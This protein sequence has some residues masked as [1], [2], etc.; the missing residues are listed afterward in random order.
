MPDIEALKRRVCEAIDRRAS[1]LIETADWIHAHPEIGHQEREASKRLADRLSEGGAQVEMGTAGMETAFSAELLG[2]SA[3]PKIAVL[4]EYDALPK[5]GH[6]CGH[7]LIAMSALGAGLALSEVLG[8]LDGTV[9]VLGTPAEE[10]A[11]P[12]AGGKVHM[13]Q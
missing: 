12:N 6:G 13:V 9:V 5:L 7:N 3:G 10:S 4:A 11:A 1:E 8:E 2:S